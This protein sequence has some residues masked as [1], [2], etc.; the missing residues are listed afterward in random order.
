MLDMGFYDQVVRIVKA[1]PK[2]RV[3]LLFSATIPA[4][5]RRICREYMKQPQTIEIESQAMTVETVEQVYYRVERNEKRVQLNRLLLVE[6][7]ESCLIFCNTRI[8]VDQVQ[9][10]L[11]RK[12]YACQALHGE[13]P[14]AKRLKTIQQFKQGV[15]HLLVAT[16]VAAR[17]IQIDDLSLVINYDV[18]N[19]KDNYVHRVG[20]TA[21]AGKTGRAIT[22]V[23]GDDIMSLYE[24]EEHI[25]ARI[26]ESE[27]PSEADYN[28]YRA[29]TEKWMQANSQKSKPPRTTSEL[30]LEGNQKKRSQT[31]SHQ[32]YDKHR[33]RLA[34]AN[35]DHKTDKRIHAVHPAGQAIPIHPAGQAKLAHTAERVKPVRTVDKAVM[36]RSAQAGVVHAKRNDQNMQGNQNIQSARKAQNTKIV[37]SQDPAAKKPFLR[38]LLQRILGK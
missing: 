8:A 20:R 9:S 24:I 37:Q 4:E 26:T 13:I 6:R 38:R 15:F 14:Q 1:I 35:M 22:L 3:T 31:K 34:E 7:P 10:F 29:E 12:G 33:D 16:D 30:N 2:D 21:R 17:G 25:G 23:T 36:P 18:P 5:I 32:R 28:E 11:T 27:L 19:D